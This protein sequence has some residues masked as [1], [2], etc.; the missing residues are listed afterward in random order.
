MTNADKRIERVN[1]IK[2]TDEFDNRPGYIDSNSFYG[3]SPDSLNGWKEI[4]FEDYQ[5]VY[6][7]C[8]KTANGY[9]PIDVE[10]F[11]KFQFDI[12]LTKIKSD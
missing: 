4:N 1:Y 10:E 7:E 12:E 8:M 6:H 5:T 11:N 2:K 9:E 3:I